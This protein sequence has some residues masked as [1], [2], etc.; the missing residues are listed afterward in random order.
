M[1]RVNW[2]AKD[3]NLNYATSVHVKSNDTSETN[4]L[5]DVDNDAEKSF[6]H[7]GLRVRSNRDQSAVDSQFSY[8]FHMKTTCKLEDTSRGILQTGQLDDSTVS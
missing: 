4:V 5:E 2:Y 3:T 7:Y 6:R 8:G 1:F